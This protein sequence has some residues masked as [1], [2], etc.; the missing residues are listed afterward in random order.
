MEP[1]GCPNNKGKDEV[2]EIN[3]KVNIVKLFIK[4]KMSN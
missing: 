1:Y 2:R 3:E 4:N